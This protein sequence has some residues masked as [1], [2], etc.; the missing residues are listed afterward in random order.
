MPFI[1]ALIGAGINGIAGAF[2][3]GPQKQATQQ[4]TTQSQ[5][6]VISSNVQPLQTGILGSALSGLSAPNMA[7]Y[8]SSGMQNIAQQ[9]QANQ[10][11]LNNTLAARGLTYSSPLATAESTGIQ[12]NTGNQQNQF[13]NSVPL[14]QQQLLQ[15]N[16][17]GA[18]NAFRANPY[19]TTGT[20]NITGNGS[21]TPSGGILGGLV[22]GLGTG[23][24]MGNGSGGTNLGSI[25]GS[26]GIG[27]G[28]GS[29][30]N[31]PVMNPGTG[32]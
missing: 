31:I 13:L 10:N 6:P 23:L 32:E 3:G 9:G 26:L 25:L 4:N 27:G 5:T 21:I 20:Q 17:A 28:G 7:G 19:G 22:S 8:T 16:L 30:I 14:V 2:Q 18:V 29:N 11:I 1:G 15:Q 24:A 12:Q